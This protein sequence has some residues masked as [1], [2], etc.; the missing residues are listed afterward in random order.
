[1]V[2]PLKHFCPLPCITLL[3][4]LHYYH[5]IKGDLGEA[6]DSLG[7]PNSELTVYIWLY[8]HLCI[9]TTVVFVCLCNIGLF[10]D[11]RCILLSQ[12]TFSSRTLGTI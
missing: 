11:L 3:H 7:V 1:M 5:H 12:T 6:S 8:M 2:L 10:M 4:S 9:F